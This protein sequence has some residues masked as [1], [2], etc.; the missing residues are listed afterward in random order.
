M[1]RESIFIVE[2]ERII[3]M[4]L[5]HRLE[6]MGYRVC[7]SASDANA[8]ILGIR[9]LKPDLVLMDI[10]LQGLSTGSK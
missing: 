6:R 1:S 4:D 3:A 7:G 2:D 9:D 10:V 8:A 5:Q